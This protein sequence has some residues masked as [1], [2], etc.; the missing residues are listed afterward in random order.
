[1]R[2]TLVHLHIECA[3]EIFLDL[4]VVEVM[5]MRKLSQVGSRNI[6][7]IFF[8][9]VGSR[10]SF[11]TVGEMIISTVLCSVPGQVVVHF[12]LFSIT[13]AFTTSLFRE[14]DLITT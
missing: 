4:V 2:L 7:D 13:M 8:L 1:M 14:S 5:R 9:K 3:L 12:P 6:E 10:L 11:C